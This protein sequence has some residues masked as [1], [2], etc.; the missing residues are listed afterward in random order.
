MYRITAAEM[1][2]CQE[3]Y[4]KNYPSFKP[5]SMST[6]DSDHIINNFKGILKT[7][8]GRDT[9][10]YC[11][12]DDNK[13]E[14]YLSKF[15]KGSD[16]LFLGTGTGREL[17]IAKDMGF[18]PV[19]T[20][21]GSRNV[22]YGREYLGLTEMELIE[23][24]NE[25]L[26]FTRGSFD[27]VTG[28]QVFEHAMAPMQFLLEQYRVLKEGGTLLLE[29]PAAK[30]HQGG[31]N[32]HHQVCYVPGQAKSLLEKASFS[33]IK[34]YYSDMTDVAEDDMWRGDT[35]DENLMLCVEGTKVPS[36]QEY[37]RNYLKSR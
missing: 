24:P 29:W 7:Q 5:F 26:P 8:N 14:R 37:I 4:K 16:V 12:E 31:D 35:G 28:F 11:I 22:F 25:A 10:D 34:L 18:N 19:G 13:V 36:Q 20:T 23:C 1:M 27:V 15:P 33:G 3:E 30:F 17:L 6:A 21:L 2:S 32:P 9:D